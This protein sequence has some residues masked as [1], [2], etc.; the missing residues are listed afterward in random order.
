MSQ[1]PLMDKEQIIQNLKL[2]GEELEALQLTQPARLLMIGGGYMLTQIGNRPFTEDVDVFT[3]LDKYSEDYRRFRSAIH[4]IADD[5]HVSQKW[6]TD[7]IGD[8]MEILGPVPEG[9]LWLKH[10][11]LE[12][13]I[14][15]P[16]YILLLKLIAGR[17][18]DLQ[19]I[20]P[21]CRKLRLMK[22]EQAE[23]WLRK[24]VVKYQLDH[25][26][27]EDHRENI[28]RMFDAVFDV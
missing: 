22:R 12:V 11:L 9:K 10:G 17:N 24:Q 1:Q 16:Q 26:V 7:N 14:P 15:E 20:R 8:F 21:L 13:Y 6:V 2:L 4:F 28:N 5:T 27:V 23:R 3:S 25:L 19:D 18:K